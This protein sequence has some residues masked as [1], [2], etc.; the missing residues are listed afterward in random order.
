M[1][2]KIEYVLSCLFIENGHK[3]SVFSKDIPQ[4]HLYYWNILKKSVF[5]NDKLLI[6]GSSMNE[7]IST[8]QTAE[9]PSVMY[10][11]VP[12][13]NIITMKGKVNLQHA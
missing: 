6:E 7:A 1:Q 3:F 8:Q 10:K 9:I 12:F 5:F 11:P 13:V 2:F 4:Y